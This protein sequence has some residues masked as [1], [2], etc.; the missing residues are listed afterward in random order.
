MDIDG[1]YNNG[2]FTQQQ[3]AQ[4]HQHGIIEQHGIQHQPI[5]PQ[6]LTQ[7]AANM[8]HKQPPNQRRRIRKQKNNVA[9]QPSKFN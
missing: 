7:C 9:G 3:M 5:T 1:R 2:T 4:L 8:D 6:Q